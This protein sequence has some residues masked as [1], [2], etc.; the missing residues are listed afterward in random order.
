MRGLPHFRGAREG[1][2]PS[3]MLTASPQGQTQLY[4]ASSWVSPRGTGGASGDRDFAELLSRA[5]AP[6]V[7]A[8]AGE[9]VHRQEVLVAVGHGEGAGREARICEDRAVL[10]PQL[11][12]VPR[13]P[14]PARVE[15]G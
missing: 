2:I 10:P 4:T 8:L 13:G 12:R 6:V 1:F 5:V 14:R 3:E 11:G 15:G 9:V 7:E